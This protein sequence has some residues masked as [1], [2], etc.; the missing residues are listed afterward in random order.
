MPL[1]GLR[2]E[3]ATQERPHLDTL[4]HILSRHCNEVVAA[5][6]APSGPR[7]AAGETR[8]SVAAEAS[9]SDSTATGVDSG[10]SS[11]CR[12]GCGMAAWLIFQVLPKRKAFVTLV[13]T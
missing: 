3:A 2:R 13:Q 4:V 5:S 12:I 6:L 10:A 9:V 7:T 8:P 1:H 11:G